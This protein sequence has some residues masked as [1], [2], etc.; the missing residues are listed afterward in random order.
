MNTHMYNVNGV[1]FW[2]FDSRYRARAPTT[3]DGASTRK[4]L[5]EM[6]VRLVLAVGSERK[7]VTLSVGDTF[8]GRKTFGLPDRQVSRKQVV[9]RVSSDGTLRIRKVGYP[10]QA[11]PALQPAPSM[12]MFLS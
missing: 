10:P 11:D 8:I 9:C 12:L 7:E 1:Y 5:D 2:S 6:A 4:P 3:T